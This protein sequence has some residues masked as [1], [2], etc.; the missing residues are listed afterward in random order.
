MDVLEG[1]E[2]DAA[3]GKEEPLLLMLE[4]VAGGREVSTRVFSFARSALLPTRM[5]VR[6]GEARARASLMKVG[7]AVKVGCE[8]KS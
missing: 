8:V 5:T 4:G 7:R 6:F 2:L 1:T 3:K